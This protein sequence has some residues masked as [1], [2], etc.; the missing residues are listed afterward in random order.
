LSRHFAAIPAPARKYS[1]NHRSVVLRQ[2]PLLHV[3]LNSSSLL[4]LPLAVCTNRTTSVSF[5]KILINSTSNLMEIGR[6]NVGGENMSKLEASKNRESLCS[7][8]GGFRLVITILVYKRYI[9]PMNLVRETI[10]WDL[11]PCRLI[12]I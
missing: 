6:C 2:V 7:G 8:G 12:E 9:P 3:L 10:S 11:T 4:I 5:T 1:D